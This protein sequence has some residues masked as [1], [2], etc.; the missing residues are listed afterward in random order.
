MQSHLPDIKEKIGTA[1]AYLTLGIWGFVW[2]LISSRHFYDQKAFVR[3]H[4]YQSIF[5]GVLYMIIPQGF[6]ILF[7]LIIQIINLIPG[8]SLITNPLHILHGILQTIVHY[9]GLILILYCII[10]CFYG[11]FTNIPLISQ[12]INRMLR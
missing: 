9:G 6:A 10:F 12:M 3:F 7:S 2:L 1:V 11:K 5:I 8:S 4:C